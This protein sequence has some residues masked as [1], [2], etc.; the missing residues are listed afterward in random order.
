MR[1]VNIISIIKHE[2]TRSESTAKLYIIKME[3]NSFQFKEFH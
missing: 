3:A 2:I 1:S